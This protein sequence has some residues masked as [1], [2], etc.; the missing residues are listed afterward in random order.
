MYVN[1][2]TLSHLM[3]PYGALVSHKLMGIYFCSFKL[4][5]IGG[6]DLAKIQTDVPRSNKL[7]PARVST[8]PKIYA[9]YS[10]V[11]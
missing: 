2:L 4:F 9:G 11:L 7:A 1:E 6:K 8:Q 10:H 3:M 5:L